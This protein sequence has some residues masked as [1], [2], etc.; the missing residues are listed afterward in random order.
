[1]SKKATGLNPTMNDR[2]QQ[3]WTSSQPENAD[4][5]GAI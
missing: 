4:E 3:M 5:S 1:M 2:E